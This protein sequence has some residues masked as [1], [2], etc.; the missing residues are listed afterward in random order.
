MGKRFYVY[1]S[2]TVFALVMLFSSCSSTDSSDSQGTFE[3]ASGPGSGEETTIKDISGVFA[4]QGIEFVTSKTVQDPQTGKA[5][6]GY[7][8]KYTGKTSCGCYHGYATPKAGNID[9]NGYPIDYTDKSKW[10]CL[11]KVRDSKGNVTM[12][13][14]WVTDAP[15]YCLVLSGTPYTMGYQEGFLRPEGTLAMTSTFLKEA[16]FSQF[17]LLGIS[18]D[19]TD[20]ITDEIFAWFWKNL[21]KMVLAEKARTDRAIAG[22][23][24]DPSAIPPSV[25]EEVQGIADGATAGLKAIGRTEKVTFNEVFAISEGIDALF[26]YVLKFIFNPSLDAET[27]Q[28]IADLLKIL[29][30]N[31]G[32][33]LANG[34]FGT[35]EIQVT[36]DLKVLF[37]KRQANPLIRFGCNGFMVTGNLTNDGKTYH[38]RDF[39]FTT[40]GVFQDE[41]A[42]VIYLPA[43]GYPFVTINS[44]GFVGQMVGMNSQGV[45]VGVDISLSGAVSKEPGVGCLIVNREL[46]NSCATIDEAV[47]RFRQF[48]RGVPWDYMVADD[49]PSAQYG[50]S[51]VFEAIM[52]DPACNGYDQLPWLLRTKIQP[53]IKNLK[54]SE[55]QNSD[56]FN[57]DGSIRSGTMLRGAKWVFPDAFKQTIDA[58]KTPDLSDQ[59]SYLK[60]YGEG[61]GPNG[62]EYTF[63]DQFESDD[64]IIVVTNEF[65]IPRMRISQFESI[66]QMGYVSGALPE[67]VWRYQYCLQLILD[68]KNS[69]NKIDFFGPGDYPAI[70]TAGWII[71]F[72]NPNDVFSPD[73]PHACSLAPDGFKFKPSVKQNDFYVPRFR[74][75]D[76]LH[77]IMNNTDKV[78]K[79]LYGYLPDPWVGADLKQ[80]IAWYYGKS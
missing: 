8:G 12:V 65:L 69:G 6:T 28:Q 54:N 46:L 75:V 71:D 56:D 78:M 1:L 43:S 51:V 52:S 41:S 33:L 68:Q 58:A 34:N 20:P 18:I 45:S 31:G 14:A 35:D 76:G 26:A 74:D 77:A 60:W 64:D 24:N 25:L 40:G 27:L 32:K 44:P 30:N 15:K 73:K 38:G 62:S 79:G 11:K 61:G 5:Y 47:A 59:E 29:L 67:M 57:A 16:L 2:V 10:N 22:K 70:G 66:V 17:G 39:M 42:M 4:N 7:L 72:L 49:T 36:P 37:P 23:R 50:N 13:D 19:T 63:P 21:E 53:Y 3:D 9:A 80:F 55:D 48:K